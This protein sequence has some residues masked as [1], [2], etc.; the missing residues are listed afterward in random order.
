MVI[1]YLQ[2]ALPQLRFEIVDSGEH[3]RNH[4]QLP[5]PVCN[6]AEYYIMN[7]AG[8]FVEIGCLDAEYPATSV[9]EIRRILAR[10]GKL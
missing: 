10:Y 3:Y 9:E 8:Q 5:M 2:T 1:N 4:P 6:D 7:T